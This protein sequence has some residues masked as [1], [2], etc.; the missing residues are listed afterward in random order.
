MS[1]NLRKR[2]IW[3]GRR[4]RWRWN[5]IWRFAWSE[6]RLIDWLIS[7]FVFGSAFGQL[8]FGARN[9]SWSYAGPGTS[10]T[11][12]PK[13][14]WRKVEKTAFIIKRA[15]AAL[16]LYWDFIPLLLFLA[17]GL[18]PG[19]QSFGL[20]HQC[21]P[22]GADRELRAVHPRRICAGKVS[23]ELPNVRKC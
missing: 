8:S 15:S 10:Y 22:R 6:R 11:N 19:I 1:N 20:D 5:W 3:S 2:R 14:I 13:K 16:L 23:K 12:A 9:D 17:E 4:R 18:G 7:S 21:D